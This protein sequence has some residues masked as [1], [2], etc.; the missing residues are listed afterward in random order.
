[1]TME[2]RYLTEGGVRAATEMM[3][4]DGARLMDE[5]Y[6][7]WAGRV[8]DDWARILSGIIMNGMY[9]RDVLPTGTR[10]LCAVAALTALHRIDELRNHLRIALHC[11]PVEQVRE[12]ILQMSILG[13]MP[14]TLNG[15]RILDEVLAEG[16]VNTAEVVTLGDR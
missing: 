5:R 8:D 15:L 14:V 16:D 3:G 2:Y 1:M 6:G 10:E 7:W 9:S 13:G 12:V 11:N 4:P